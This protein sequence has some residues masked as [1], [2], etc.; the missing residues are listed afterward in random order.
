VL[1]FIKVK[2]RMATQ[3]RFKHVNGRNGKVESI[4]MNCLLAVGIFSSDKELLAGESMHHCNREAREI[5]LHKFQSEDRPKSI[6]VWTWNK[7]VAILP[8]RGETHNYWPES[9]D[10]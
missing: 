7:L 10:E 5:G 1:F 6:L 8:R 2:R 3:R 4:C 9:H